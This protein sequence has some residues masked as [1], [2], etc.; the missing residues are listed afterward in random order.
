MTHLRFTSTVFLTLVAVLSAKL[1][2]TQSAMPRASSPDARQAIEHLRAA[3]YARDFDAGYRESGALVQRFPD[4][5]ELRAWRVVFM[6]ASRPLLEMA[7]LKPEA[8]DAADA[9]AQIS[10]S[11]PWYAFARGTAAATLPS[12]LDKALKFAD[13]ALSAQP[14]NEEFIQLKVSV[15][16]RM[17]LRTEAETFLDG[18]IKKAPSAQLLAAKAEVIAA[19]VNGPAT[20]RDPDAVARSLAVYA[21]VRAIDPANV[22]G[23]AL[24][25]GLSCAGTPLPNARTAEGYPLY[26]RA[27]ELAPFAE[28]VHDKYWRAILALPDRSDDSKR[29]EIEAD[30]DRTLAARPNDPFPIAMA[31]AGYRVL[32]AKLPEGATTGLKEKA[33]A[34]EQRVLGEFSASLVAN[35]VWNWHLLWYFMEPDYATLSAAEAAEADAANFKTLAALVDQP[36]G[37]SRTLLSNIY[38]WSSVATDPRLDEKTLVRRI[39]AWDRVDQTDVG[40]FQ[41][42]QLAD[43][44]FD[45]AY[46]RQITLRGDELCRAGISNTREVYQILGDYAQ[47]LDNCG[48]TTHEALGWIAFAEGRLPEAERE[49]RAA[50]AFKSNRGDVSTLYRLGQVLEAAGKFDDAEEQYVNGIAAEG[51]VRGSGSRNRKAL[52][53]LYRSRHADSPAGFDPYLRDTAE[54][55]RIRHRQEIAASRLVPA[56]PLRSFS[57]ENLGTGDRFDSGSL[58]GKIVVINVWGTWCGPCVAE[59]PALKKFYDSVKADPDVVFLSI[60]YNDSRKTVT[61]FMTERKLP[62]PVLLDDGWVKRAG[63]VTAFPTTLFLDRQGR[64]AF[65]QVG[66][67]TALDDCALR[68]EILKADPVRE[69]VTR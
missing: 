43:R 14:A 5:P 15:L 31:A 4:S 30:I 28:A 2:A 66:T 67:V 27:A 63:D 9:L 32:L 47:A 12:G 50:L 44:R 53:N 68:I 1:L 61:D 18:R 58:T 52:E 40:P 20:R 42:I 3:Y 51:A 57:L 38:G 64:L 55:V 34:V 19:Q 48:R 65:K 13:A 62:Y 11:S 36:A 22:S 7:E 33:G 16:C 69:D 41:A 46:A 23:W 10:P 49:L 17:G 39:H 56:K 59:I 54:K 29:A 26:R 35:Q 6:S 8:R 45:L 24:D 60:D 21:E 25:A 37:K